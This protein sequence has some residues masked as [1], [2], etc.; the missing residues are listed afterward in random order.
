MNTISS[1]LSN[2]VDQLSK[3]GGELGPMIIQG[4]ILLLIVLI[5]EI[6]AQ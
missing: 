2:Y 6:L 4:L 3:V 5:L 1:G